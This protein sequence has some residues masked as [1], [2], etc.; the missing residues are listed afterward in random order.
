MLVCL[1]L[2]PHSTGPAS[3][4]PENRSSS[5]SSITRISVRASAGAQ[6]VVQAA[7][8]RDVRVRVER[9]TSKRNGSSNTASS[10]FADGY[11][12]VV[13]SPARIR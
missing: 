3:A 2:R 12:C 7:A 8:E 9:L 10:R 13:F 1:L 11:Q 5:S 6:A 4:K